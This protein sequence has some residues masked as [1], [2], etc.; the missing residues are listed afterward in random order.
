MVSSSLQT[1]D[2]M[3]GN[4]IADINPRNRP[5]SMLGEYLYACQYFDGDS[6]DDLV[7]V[8]GSG[9]GFMEVKCIFY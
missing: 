8:G 5:R 9:T 4:L 1:W 6:S 2:F 7:V 3:S